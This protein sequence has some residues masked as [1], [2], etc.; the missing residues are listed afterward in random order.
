MKIKITGASGY[1][2]IKISSE[3]KKQGHEVSGIER[4]LIYS[5]SVILS[6]EIDDLLS[7]FE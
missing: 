7:F 3:L 4:R 2:G 5:S 1:L 6:N